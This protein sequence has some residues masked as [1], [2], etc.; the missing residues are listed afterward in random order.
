M[1]W[2]GMQWNGNQSIEDF[3][4]QE[5]CGDGEH[6]KPVFYSK[7]S[8]STHF[9][10]IED[11]AGKK[12]MIVILVQFQ[13]N[14]YGDRDILYKDIDESMGPAELANQKTLN[15]L[16]KNIPVPPNDYAKDWRERSYRSILQKKAMSGREYHYPII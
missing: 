3:L 13:K 7:K 15:W 16:E 11:N 8:N 6:I 14:S 12:F 5:V 9:L 10:G 1:G 2:L 4:K